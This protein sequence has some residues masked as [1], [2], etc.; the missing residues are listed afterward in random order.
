MTKHKG[1]VV[2]LGFAEAKSSLVGSVRQGV[3][4][5]LSLAIALTPTVTSAVCLQ[6]NTANG[7]VPSRLLR[8]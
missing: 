6:H 2:S 8:S 3:A 4:L 7:K 5:L 1:R